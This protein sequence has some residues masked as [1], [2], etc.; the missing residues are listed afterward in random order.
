MFPDYTCAGWEAWLSDHLPHAFAICVA[1]IIVVFGLKA[2]MKSR[3]A[4]DL[5]IPLAVWNL[6]LSIFSAI[7]AYY[8]LPKLVS[9]LMFGFR[10]TVCADPIKAYCHGDSG[11]WTILFVLSKIPEMV[12][13]LFIVLRKRPL[14]FLHWY[15]HVTVML[16]CWHAVASY[17]ANGLWFA[18]MNLTVH[19]VMYLYYFLTALGYRPSWGQFVTRMQ[20]AQMVIGVVV[21]AASTVF[22]Y[23]ATAAEPCHLNPTNV[24]ASLIMY[25]SYL[26]LFVAL[27]LNRWTE[28]PSKSTERPQKTD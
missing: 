27:Y 7:G 25:A 4:F 3:K 2:V 9:N 16:Y 20:I 28:R 21:V 8:T 12:D 11:L 15:H 14:T 24:H 22:M 6:G 5:R 17:S 19:A 23:S 1:Y 18:A 10:Y 26:V 13:T